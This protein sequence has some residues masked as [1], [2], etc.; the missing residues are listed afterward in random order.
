M[1]K[2]SQWTKNFKER[3]NGWSKKKK[4][5]YGAIIIGILAALIYLG[6]SLNT[7]KYGVLFSTMDNNYI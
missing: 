5:A 4:I 6:I 3:L 7:T 2:L 1:N